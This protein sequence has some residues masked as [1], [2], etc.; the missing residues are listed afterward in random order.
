MGAPEVTK[1]LEDLVA[2]SDRVIAAA[3]RLKVPVRL[4]GGLAIRRLCPAA[5]QP[6]LKRVYADLDLAIAGHT[7]HSPLKELMIGLGYQADVQFNTINGST[8]LLYHDPFHGRH[9]DVFVDAIRMCHVIDFKNRLSVMEETLTP[10]DLLLSK[11]QIVQLNAKDLLDAVALLHDQPIVSGTNG[12]IDGTYLADI[13]GG[14]WPLWRTS[15]LTLAKIQHA[16]ID[17]LE[18][19]A[20]LRVLGSIS[21][22]TDILD[23]GRKSLRWRARAQVGDRI[24]WYEL[25][26]EVG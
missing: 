25:P 16:V 9:V 2:E 24:R 20:R 7:S 17:L 18:V 1:P 13:W 15:Q 4:A 23:S 19:D 21:A 6:P 12:G 26:D 3:Q 11:L 22:L 14:D 5:R 10:S 8:R